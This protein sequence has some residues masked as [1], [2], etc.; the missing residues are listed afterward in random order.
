[1]LPALQG[2]RSASTPHL[3]L[4]APPGKTPSCVALA[5]QATRQ[6]T[7]ASVEFY[8]PDRAKFLGPFSEGV[9]PSYLKGEEQISGVDHYP[10]A[11]RGA[12][13]CCG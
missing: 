2:P 11:T 8:G 9:T 5:L 3:R 12:V 6:V 1:M 10:L 13:G 7:R 4:I